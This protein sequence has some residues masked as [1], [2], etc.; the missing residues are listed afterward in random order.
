MKLL[1]KACDMLELIE[2]AL[3]DRA[4]FL[5]EPSTNNMLWVRK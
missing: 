2:P 4:A 1:Y 5:I 3:R